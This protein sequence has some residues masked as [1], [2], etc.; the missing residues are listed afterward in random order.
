MWAIIDG[1]APKE[2]IDSLKKQFDVLEF[3][4]S[5]I[6]Y[7]EVSGHPDIFIFQ[8]N[9]ELIIAPNSPK[10]LI[11]FLDERKVIY[12]FGDKQVGTDLENSTQYNCI[13]TDRILLHKKGFTDKTI[14]ANS[15][16]KKFINLPQAY[17]RCS[18]TMINEDTYIT[19]DKGIEKILLKEYLNVLGVSSRQILLPG[20]PYGFFGG[21]N[22]IV[23]NKFYL[24][25]SL[26]Y[27]ENGKMIEQFITK[28]NLQIVELYNGPLYDGGGIFFG[29]R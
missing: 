29:D 27:H 23:N 22:G 20:Y 7:E 3:S 18:L 28:N 8:D 19:S 4:S 26:R 1:R 2:A 15:T 16:N 11:D 25:G 24:I 9:K 14:L 13:S 10:A 17:T 5:N 21:T 6:T 12:S